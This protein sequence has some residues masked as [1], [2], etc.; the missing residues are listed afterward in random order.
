MST[1]QTVVL[2]ERSKR[3]PLWS[4]NFLSNWFFVWVVPILKAARTSKPLLF[5]LRSDESSRKNVESLESTFIEMRKSN[6]YIR[7]MQRNGHHLCSAVP[8]FRPRVPLHCRI[9][10]CLDC[11][12]MGRCVVSTQ[13]FFAVPDCPRHG[14]R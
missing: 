8:S 2:K 10:I 6:P 12:Y 3:N 1:S 4:Q 5:D 7:L 9:Q 11:F 14:Y 13:D